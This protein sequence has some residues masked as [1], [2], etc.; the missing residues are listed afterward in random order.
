MELVKIWLNM[1]LPERPQPWRGVDHGF[2]GWGLGENLCEANSCGESVFELTN[3]IRG[4]LGG[5][6]PQ[7][8]HCCRTLQNSEISLVQQD[9][10]GELNL[11]ITRWLGL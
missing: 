4:H 6:N 9:I 2:E 1:R 7:T 8:V 10:G 3:A 11:G 5:Q